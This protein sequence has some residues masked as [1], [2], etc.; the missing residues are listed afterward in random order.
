MNHSIKGGL[1]GDLSEDQKAELRKVPGT[2]HNTE[3]FGA[4]DGPGIRYIFFLQG[5]PLRCLYCHNPDAIPG[6]GGTIWTAEKAAKEVMRYKSFIKSGGVTFSGGE[7]LLQPEFVYAAA[8]LLRDEGISTAID[9]S[10]SQ[11][12]ENPAVRKAI[13]AADLLLLDIKAWNSEV[14]VALTGKD[15][16]NALATLEYC[17]S[18]Q[19]PV[20]IRHVLLSGYTMDDGQLSAMADCLTTYK[21][22]D[23]VELLPFHKLGEPKWQEM[24]KNYL[25]GDTAATSKA[26]AERAKAVMSARGLRVQ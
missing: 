1:K 22:V 7:P 18:T 3:S 2:V 24:G 11:N 8:V 4:V 19:K 9:T 23:R 15:T 17:E 13:D 16:K 20:W 21:C 12:P 25:L 10:G 26:Q 14:A 6:S 5:C